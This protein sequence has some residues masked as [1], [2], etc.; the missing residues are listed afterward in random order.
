MSRLIY[1]AGL[2]LGMV[3]PCY[4]GTIASSD[5]LEI[6]RENGLRFLDSYDAQVNE[7]VIRFATFMDSYEID[8]LSAKVRMEENE[9]LFDFNNDTLV[10]SADFQFMR[11]DLPAAEYREIEKRPFPLKLKAMDTFEQNPPV[12]FFRTH[13]GDVS[14]FSTEDFVRPMSIPEPAS[15]TIMSVGLISLLSLRRSLASRRRA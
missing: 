13:D 5:A 7:P 2:L 10:D 6:A 4:G 8:L 15:W 14:Q 12:S 9:R 1:F 11:G 3:V